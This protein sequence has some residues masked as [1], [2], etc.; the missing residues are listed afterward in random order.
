MSYVEGKLRAAGCT[1][2]RRTCTSCAG[3]TQNLVAEWPKGDAN[4]V[5]ILGAHLDSVSA[6]A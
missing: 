3:R 6:T 5:R 2:T 4:R 1:V